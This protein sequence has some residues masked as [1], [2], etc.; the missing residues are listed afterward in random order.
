MNLFDYTDSYTVIYIAIQLS[1]DVL[2]YY[3]LLYTIYCI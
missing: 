1:K 2:C 3:Y